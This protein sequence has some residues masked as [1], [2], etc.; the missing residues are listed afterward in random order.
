M[1]LTNGVKKLRAFL[2]SQTIS[3]R[4]AAKAI[5]VSG[6][7]M[8]DWLAGRK[9]PTPPH[10]RAIEIWTKGRVAETDWVS[11][12]ERAA[13]NRAESVSPFEPTSVASKGAA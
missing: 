12:R 10:R 9:T 1:T 3:K 2:V 6:P 8:L 5:G 4:G 7:T 13:A 11:E